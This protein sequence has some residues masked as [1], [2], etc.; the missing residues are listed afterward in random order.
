MVSLV[1]L[2]SSFLPLVVFFFSQF[3][4]SAAIERKGITEHKKKTGLRV[5]NEET[6]KTKGM[7]LNSPNQK[8]WP[9]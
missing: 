6:S 9:A 5:K 2:V 3:C 7:I 4:P 1:L 8:V